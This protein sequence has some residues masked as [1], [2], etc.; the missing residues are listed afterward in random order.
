[1]ISVKR[2][3]FPGDGDKKWHEIAISGIGLLRN[4]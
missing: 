3:D 2:Q 4:E 1:M